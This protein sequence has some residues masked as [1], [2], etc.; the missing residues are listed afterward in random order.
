[1]SMWERIAKVS[2]FCV[3]DLRQQPMVAI[4]SVT[5]ALLTVLGALGLSNYLR[6]RAIQVDEAHGRN[7]SY[8]LAQQEDRTFQSVDNVISSLIDQLDAARDVNELQNLAAGADFQRVMQRR[9]V[10]VMDIDN[11][12]VIN[13]NGL[14]VN[15]SQEGPIPQA[16][17]SKR[18]YVSNFRSA[19]LSGA[20]LS[21]PF[22]SPTIGSWEVALSKR[23]SAPDGSFLGVVIGVLELHSLEQYFSGITRGPNGSI[24]MDR[25]DGINLARY[26]HVNALIGSSVSSNEVFR[27]FVLKGKDGVA[28]HASYFDG[29]DRIIAV[30][31]AEHFPL[32]V[33]VTMSMSDVLADWRRQST[34]LEV[35]A[36]FLAAFILVGGLILVRRINQLAKSNYDLGIA[37]ER[38]ATQANSAVQAER[39]NFA[40]ENMCQGLVMFDADDRVIVCNA[41]YAEL[42][43]LPLELTK[44]GTSKEDLTA[45]RLTVGTD[46]LSGTPSRETRGHA[47]IFYNHLSD[48]RIIVIKRQMTEGGGWVST[49]EDITDLRNAEAKIAHMARHD[50]LTDLPNRRMFGDALESLLTDR[51]DGP[52]IAVLYIDLDRF[53]GV[54]DS[55][56]HGVG[57]ALLRAAASRLAAIIRAGDLV[58]RL[59]GDEF[60]II[61]H[62]SQTPAEA[63]DYSELIIAALNAPYHIEGRTLV[64][65][66]SIGIAVA[67]QDGEEAE[68]LIRNA[69]LALYAAK[70]GG[71]GS[72]SY[73]R[74]ELV[75]E[76]QR[77]QALKVDLQRALERR[78]FELYFQ[79]LVSIC[80]QRLQCFE[81]LLRWNSP[82]R[83]L[84][85]PAEF[86]E[87]VE[88][89]G[90][91]IPLGDWVIHE[92]C[93]QAMLWPDAIKVAVNLS[94]AQFR[95]KDLAQKVRSA[96][97]S[98]GLP[99][100]RL[101]LE[102]TESLM[103]Q[104][105]EGTIS[106][107]HEFREMG[108]QI[109]MDD[110]GTGYSSLSYLRLFP[111]NKIKIDRS[112]INDLGSREDSAV[113]VRAAASIAR[114]LDMITTAEG[115]ETLDQLLRAGLEGCTQ[116]QGYLFGKPMP[117]AATRSFIEEKMKLAA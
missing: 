33:A 7:L 15:Q 94:V 78:E 62:L 98:S 41:R 34:I 66:A 40:F 79:P 81:A 29:V 43:K 92:A 108:I 109:A 111:F 70:A 58:A 45:Y 19:H 106:T 56:G 57:D 17:L 73:F 9:I 69:D 64:V 25:I 82:D 68:Q 87:V 93:R 117:A 12:A 61:Q 116:A 89:I 50:A 39:F 95:D 96:L 59:G 31:R 10:G 32:V 110:F 30:H 77:R 37:R 38:E 101:E 54:N 46:K 36:W 14:L 5:L 84:V 35:G 83:G 8:V 18:D 99:G 91:I 102:I 20:Y 115:V 86:I 49:H 44:A 90:L 112:F 71:R 55:L 113:I 114:S 52:S 11:I 6:D 85:G 24:S 42:Y 97:Y 26:P 51:R 28:R 4:L 75:A 105:V 2:R 47:D 16:D 22:P 1:M 63:G 104:E 27:Q 60:A 23:I 76:I 80:D 107:L 13:A 3:K 72:F 100:D 53:K 103:I 21:I 67:P 65:G 88:E 74:A 48:G